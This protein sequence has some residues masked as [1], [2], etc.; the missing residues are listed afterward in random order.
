MGGPSLQTLS[1]GINIPFPPRHPFLPHPPPP[2]TH[3]RGSP[4]G[5]LPEP[6]ASPRGQGLVPLAGDSYQSVLTEGFLSS[7]RSIANMITAGG[8]GLR[9]G[10]RFGK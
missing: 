8:S 5:G 2:T 4:N 3:L 7:H 10:L 9:L 1:Y 6:T